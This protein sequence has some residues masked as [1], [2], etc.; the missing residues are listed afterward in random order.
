M[1]SDGLIGRRKYLS[2]Q[3]KSENIYQKLKEEIEPLYK[4]RIDLVQNLQ[5]FYYVREH[6]K[7]PKVSVQDLNEVRVKIMYDLAL[8]DIEVKRI[9]DEMQVNHKKKIDAFQEYTKA[10]KKINSEGFIFNND[11][12]AVPQR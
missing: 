3:T 1:S 4:K 10:N 11:S 5:Y 2:A 6:E 8:I 9:T 7:I 12:Q